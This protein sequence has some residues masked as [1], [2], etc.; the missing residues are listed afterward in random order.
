MLPRLSP[1]HRLLTLSALLFLSSRVWAAND[2]PALQDTVAWGRIVTVWHIMID[3]SSGAI[4]SS[5]RLQAI[6][7]QLDQAEAAITELVSQQLLP[8]EVG[9]ELRRVLHSRRQYIQGRCYPT[10]ARSDLTQAEATRS[11]SHWVMEMQ[12]S[13]LRQQSPSIQLDPKLRDAIRAN[14]ERELSFQRQL[15]DLEAKQ[16]QRRQA[17][18]QEQ[19]ERETRVDWNQFEE[20]CAREWR[21]L[22]AA[23]QE[24]RVPVDRATRRLVP[25]L[26]DLT[27]SQP[28][29][30]LAGHLPSGH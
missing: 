20:K 9:E 2:K 8:Q 26:M 28:P 29:G 19:E 23:Y 27:T 7:P 11:A 24:R 18:T 12:Y 3:H 5:E 1:S 10:S 21:S 13:L 6:L 4:F 22:F 17:L 30:G 16:E 25:Y 15:A 14:L